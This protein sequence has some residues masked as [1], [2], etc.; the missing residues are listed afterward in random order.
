MD[1]EGYLPVL[2]S[3]SQFQNMSQLFGGPRDITLKIINL[4]NPIMFRDSGIAKD[5][6]KMLRHMYLIHDMLE[7]WESSLIT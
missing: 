2:T 7:E 1:M 4:A 3:K 5:E 6:S